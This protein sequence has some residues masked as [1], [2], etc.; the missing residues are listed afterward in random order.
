MSVILM[1]LIFWL[2]KLI[3]VKYDHLVYPKLVTSSVSIVIFVIINSKVNFWFGIFK[4]S[5]LLIENNV[6]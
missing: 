4:S 5:L 1:V 6:K 3:L 2:R